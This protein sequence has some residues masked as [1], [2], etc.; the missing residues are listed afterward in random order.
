MHE[1][2]VNEVPFVNWKA[3]KTHLSAASLTGV[4]PSFK[5]SASAGPVMEILDIMDGGFACHVSG[6]K[7]LYPFCSLSSS[8]GN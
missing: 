8:V 2:V 1:Q 7:N 6:K 5:H 3:W 4:L